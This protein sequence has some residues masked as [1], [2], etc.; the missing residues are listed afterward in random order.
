MFHKLAEK[1]IFKIKFQRLKLAKNYI[2]IERRFLLRNETASRL[3]EESTRKH[4]KELI[5]GI[6]YRRPIDAVP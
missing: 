4:I 2:C 6:F 3:I 5:Q 1:L